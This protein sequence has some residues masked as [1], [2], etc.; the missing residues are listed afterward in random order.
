MVTAEEKTLLAE[1]MVTGNLHKLRHLAAMLTPEELAE[2]I[3]TSKEI[4]HTK[5]FQVLEPEKAIKTFEN[6][7]FEIQEELLNSFSK[8]QLSDTLNKISPDDRTGLFEKLP[9]ETTRKYLSLLS[10]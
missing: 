7:D 9:E 4:D 3:N 1:R 6:L 8:E 10:D 2:M 5:V